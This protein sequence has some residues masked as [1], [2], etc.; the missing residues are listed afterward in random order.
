MRS[1]STPF[2][3]RHGAAAPLLLAA[4]GLLLVGCTTRPAPP[5]PASFDLQGHRG[6]RGLAPENTL[7]AFTRALETGVSTLE[8][9]IGITRDGV[10]VIHHDERLNPA[11]TRNV[12]GVWLADPAPRIRDLSVAE[13]AG[14]NVGGLKPGSSYAAQFPDQTARD[15]EGIPKL[16]DLFELVKK[17]GDTRVRF[18]IETKLTPDHPEDTVPPE[19]MVAALL[20]VI[21]QYG[22][23]GR[24]SIQSFDWRTL[25]MVQVQ[26]PAIPTV[27]LSGRLRNFNTVSPAWNAGLPLPANGS[28]PQLVKAAGCAVWSPNF[29]DVHAN[30]LKDA[31]AQGLKLIPWTVNSREDMGRLIDLG[32]DGLITDRPDIAQ[33]VLATRKIRA[34]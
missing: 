25:K 3:F 31:H 29:Q 1:R 27:C 14:Y 15:W 4:L 21:A 34:R 30:S 32:I 5:A 24:V 23:E 18:N 8:L 2:P 11:I 26:R 17:R 22:M 20:Q 28:L 9:D 10:P 33:A 13:L 16:A 7:A 19:Q 6:A 12:H